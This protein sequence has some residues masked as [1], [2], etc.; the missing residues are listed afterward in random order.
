MSQKIIYLDPIYE[1]IGMLNQVD[2]IF[3]YYK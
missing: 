2:G 1:A 3:Y